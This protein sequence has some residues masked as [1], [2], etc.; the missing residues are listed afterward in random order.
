[1]SEKSY[2]VKV[3]SIV[4]VI[5][6]LISALSLK[7]V[8]LDKSELL[9]I[10][11][12][13]LVG[14]LIIYISCIYFD[15]VSLYD[16]YWTVQASC[17]S[18]YYFMKWF[19]HFNGLSKMEPWEWRAFIV[20]LLVNVW[21]IRLT[22]NLFMNSVDDIKHEDW[23]YSDYRTKTSSKF[24][25]FIVSLALFIIIPTLLVY[26][27]CLPIHN[28]FNSR[29]TISALDI[30]S[31]FVT[32][33]GIVFESLADSQLRSAT[34]KYAIFGSKKIQF[35]MNKGLWSLCRHPNYF[36]EILFWFGLFLFSVSAGVKMDWMQFVGPV[37]IFCIILFGSL[38]LMEERQLKN[39]PELFK[40]YMQDVPFKL[41]P[42]NIFG[43]KYTNKKE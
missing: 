17:I 14:S 12:A 15:N 23:R 42:L 43:T 25:Y 33:S 1:M 6:I 9:N 16:P 34:N 41:F 37:G 7:Y 5:A 35:V 30:V 4:Y 22:S 18:F 27:G 2:A 39:K 24:A 21:S 19:Q 10:L 3:Y 11:Y 20:F 26:F 32:Y 28:V 8:F 40:K 36:G 38:P 13:D 31:F 29:K